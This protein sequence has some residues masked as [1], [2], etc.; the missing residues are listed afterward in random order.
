MLSRNLRL[1]EPLPW[2]SSKLFCA[3]RRFLAQVANVYNVPT[4]DDKPFDVPIPE[5]SFETYHFDNP[6]YTVGT[7]KRQLKN[8]Y[9][10]M[11]TIR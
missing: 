10:D 3:K 2:V 1:K 5:D 8:M 9:Q 4:E 6:P 7:T 11:L